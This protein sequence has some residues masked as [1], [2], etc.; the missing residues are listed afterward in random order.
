MEFAVKTFLV[1]FMSTT[2]DCL[3]NI[4]TSVSEDGSSSEYSSDSY[5]MNIK[6]RK[7]PPPKK[8]KPY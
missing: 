7:S 5:N 4:Y 2:S 6:P 3:S 1:N 8:K